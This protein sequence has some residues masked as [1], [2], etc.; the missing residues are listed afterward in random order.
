MRKADGGWL[1]YHDIMPRAQRTIEYWD[2]DQ[3]G[4]V[5]GIWQRSPQTQEYY[6]IPRA[7]TFYLVDD[8]LNDSPEGLGLFRMMVQASERLKQYERLQGL[9]YEGDMRG[10]AKFFYPLAE[11]N[12]LEKDGK[13]LPEA[14]RKLIAPIEGLQK[15]F[16]TGK[17]R[18]MSFDSSVYESQ[19]QAGRPSNVRRWDMEIVRGG[20]QGFESMFRVIDWYERKLARVMGTEGMMLGEKGGSY[21]LSRDKTST[22]FA[23]VEG[24]L[25]ALRA[26]AQKDLLKQA[27]MRNGW[28]M[29]MMPTLMVSPPVHV[30]ADEMA[31]TIR[32]MAAGLKGVDD[33]AILEDA[34]LEVAARKLVSVIEQTDIALQSGG[35]GSA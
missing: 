11:L 25:E 5:E 6:Y 35:G 18:T 9:G 12:Q 16:V 23:R 14:K 3:T 7:K 27:W 32:D 19:D 10:V 1:T 31:A 21:A 22:F 13:L 2:V 33:T 24:T 15:G 28:P 30:P 34:D 20:P 29:E 4:T 26:G 8:T 17:M